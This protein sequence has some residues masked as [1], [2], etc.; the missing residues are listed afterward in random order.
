MRIPRL[1]RPL[2]LAAGLIALFALTSAGTSG[3]VN[4]VTYHA[5]WNL[6]G[7]SEGTRYAGADGAI[8]TLQPGDMEYQSFPAGTPAIGGAGYWVYFGAARTVQLPDGLPFITVELPPGQ[9]VIVGNPSGFRTAPV[10]GSDALFT[11]D[12]GRG[13]RA[14]A[15][16]LPGQGALA[17]SQ[18]GGLLVIG[19]LDG[20][21]GEHEPE[22]ADIPA[23]PVGGL[24]DDGCRNGDVLAGVY[25]PSRLQLL[26]R[27]RSATGSVASVR[28]EDDGDY[29][30]NVLL[31]PGQ[32]ELLNRRNQTIQHGGLVV[33]V[34]PAD[35]RSVPP[36]LK[37]DRIQVTGAFVLD[38]EHGWLE[39]HPAW[40]ITSL[41]R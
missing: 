23:G 19:T 17:Y 29:H 14:A 32:D 1:P 39:L 40:R 41:P 15:S 16:L 13:Y 21:A 8:Y 10:S 9:W 25:H 4:S 18:N 36:P 3:A 38:R 28:V 30:V 11:F 20:S 27:C 7:G 2:P 37:G 22:S 12:P 6:A 35:Q 31:D 33:E 34:I 5:G 26:D 24:D